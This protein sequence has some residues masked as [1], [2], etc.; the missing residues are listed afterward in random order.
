MPGLLRGV[1]TDRRDRGD[2]DRRIQ[3]CVAAPSRPVGWKE[4]QQQQQYAEPEP[5]GPAAAAA[6]PPRT[7][8]TRSS[9]SSRTSAR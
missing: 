3:P 6:P 1:A 9:P 2:S 7:T 4:E 8:W 5:G